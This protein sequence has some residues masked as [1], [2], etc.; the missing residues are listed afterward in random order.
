MSL[1]FDLR[2]G[3]APPDD[4]YFNTTDYQHGTLRLFRLSLSAELS[5]G[6]R[7]SLLVEAVSENMEARIRALYLRL[8]PFAG[9]SVDLQAGLVPPVFGAFPRR[10]YGADGPLIGM[11]LVYQYLTTMR[12]DAAPYGADDLLAVRGR[13]WYVPYPSG[14]YPPAA[15]V[16]VVSAS[17]WDTGL[18]LRVGRRPVEAAFAVTRGTLCEPRVAETNDGKQLAGRVAFWP[19]P[20]WTLGVSAAHGEYLAETVTAALPADLQGDYA[21]S[22]VGAD[23]EYARGHLLL[24]AEAVASRW[25]VPPIG[26]PAIA[27]PLRARGVYLEASYKVAPG[28]TVGAR[29]DHLS[30]SKIQG[31]TSWD[32][33]DANVTRAEAGASYSPRRHLWL[34]AV[35]QHNWRD[36]YRFSREGFL[37]AQLGLWF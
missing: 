21:Q 34:R 9:R 35:Y 22:S 6:R 16:P 32:T 37:A 27:E 3:I 23:V 5:A 1:G 12:A 13:G 11:P 33:W 17:R 4:G 18:E 19:R 8:T 15:G 14:T 30:F 28:L 10:A 24:R 7:A 26:S 25:K 36:T 2:A 29:V 31:S 20:E